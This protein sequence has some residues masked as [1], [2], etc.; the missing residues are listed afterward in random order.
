[1]DLSAILQARPHLY[2]MTTEKKNDRRDFPEVEKIADLPL[3]LS[4]L[5][6]GRID[7]DR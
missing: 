1:M 7:R 2:R 5:F 4:F 6:F 3:L